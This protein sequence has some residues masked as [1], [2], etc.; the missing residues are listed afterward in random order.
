MAI[1]IKKKLRKARART[2][3]ARDFDSFRNELLR[4]ARTYFPDKIQDFSEAS[5]GGLLLDMAAMVGDNM[6]F[7]LDHQYS[8][9]NW[10]TAVE[11][12]NIQRHIRN[13]GVKLHGAAPAVVSVSFY[14]EVPALLDG[15]DYKPSYGALPI[16]GA[17]TTVVSNDGISFS[18]VENVDF[19]ELDPAGN[20]TSK[21]SI[22]SISKD[23][24]PLTY[25]LEKQGVCISGQLATQTFQIPNSHK[26][27]RKLV[28]SNENVTDVISVEDSAGNVYYEVDSLAQDTVFKPIQNVNEDWDVVT[29]NM[30]IIPAP[31]RFIKSYDTRTRLTTIQFGSGNAEST[32]DDI[33]PDPSELALPL[34]GKKT[35]TRFSIDPNSLLE[36]HTLGLAPMDTTLT[37][38]CR[39]GGG[40]SHNVSVATI[41]VINELRMSF[42]RAV[43]VSVAQSVRSSLDINNKD[44][45]SGGSAA[46]TLDELRAQI[47]ATR[48]MQSR[49][50][51]KQ[52]LLARIYTM[53]SKFGRVY[54]AGIHSNS[55]NPLAAQLF[56]VCLDKDKHLTIAPDTLKKNMHLFLNEFRLISDAVDVLDA[57]VINFTVEFSVVVLPTANKESVIQTVIFGLKELLR[58]ENMQI[59]QP[60]VMADLINVIINTPGVLSLPHLVVRNITGTVGSRGYSDVSFDVEGFT[61]KGMVIGPV[62]SIFELRYPDLDI[63]GS[64]S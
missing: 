5:F 4:Y 21:V 16:I 54:R 40:L 9:L 61:I 60:I 58:I 12:D 53:P 17:N 57:R 2:Y 6:S 33:I 55:N 27:F 46:P 32:A 23:K 26:P 1:D 43:D 25:I 15:T 44:S 64:A 30:E 41:R 51:T 29:E 8:E 52:D 10:S 36:T 38:M 31:Y 19:S 50:V 45:A 35:F 48:Q 24:T 28:L 14:I 34:Y 20:L 49:I 63:I 59:D 37:V 13:A 39:Y 18:L 7:Y 47:P 56:V 62:G 22:S 3:L 11:S 42:P